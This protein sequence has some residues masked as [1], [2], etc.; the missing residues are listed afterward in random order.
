MNLPMTDMPS[1]IKKEVDK[2]NDTIYPFIKKVSK[3]SF[4]AF[5]L[6]AFSLINLFFMLVIMPDTRTTVA[7]ILY[8][9]MGAF[10]FA[11]SKEAKHQRKEILKVSEAFIIKRIK[12]SD[13]VMETV[14][15]RYIK[16]VKEQP[17]FAMNHFIRFLE[18]ENRLMDE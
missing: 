6:I 9:V 1:F 15:E 10:G 16:N 18:E 3:Y 8:A 11:L 2:L 14:K 17:G 7:L 5:P 4:W 12:R 13:V